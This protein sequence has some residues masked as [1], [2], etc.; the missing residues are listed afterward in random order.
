METVKTVK[1]Y[2]KKIRAKKLLKEDL[3]KGLARTEYEL[4]QAKI[5]HN[6]S[7]YRFEYNVDKIRVK[8]EDLKE[9]LLKGLIYILLNRK[10]II[11]TVESLI[12]YIKGL[13]SAIRE[14]NI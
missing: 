13:L 8:V 6:N 7:Y 11:K 1:H 14:R 9:L 2:E 12:K 4:A 3:I 5:R 10:E